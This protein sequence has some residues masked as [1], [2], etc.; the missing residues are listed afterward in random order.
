MSESVLTVAQMRAAEQAVMDQGTS[1]WELM[2]RAGTGAARWVSRMAG[3][4]PVTVLCGPGNNGGDGYVIAEILRSDGYDVT[5][6]APSDPKTGTA[7]TAKA[8]F[9][10]TVL[11][12]GSIATPVV[13]DCLFGYGL[14]REVSG[15]FA[16]LLEELK[17]HSCFKIAIDVPSCVASDDAK[18]LGPCFDYDLTLALGAWKPAHFLMPAAAIMG[19]KRLVPLALPMMEG[20]AELSHRPSFAIPAADTHK[21]KRGLV[22]VVEG[23]MPGAGLLA[24]IAAMRSGAGYVKL[25][26]DHSHPD[27]PADLVLESGDLDKLLSDERIGCVLVGPGLGRTQQSREKLQA[28]LSSGKRCVIDADALHLLDRASLSDVDPA[29]IILTPH[30]GELAALCKAFDVTS[31]DKLGRARALQDAAGVTVLA[32]G[33][34]TIL[35]GSG[36]TIFFPRGPSWL[37]VAGSGDVLAGILASRFAHH[38]DPLAASQEA[39]WLHN[40]AARRAG[41]AFCASDLAGAVGQASGAFL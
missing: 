11:A 25:L 2:R 38:H 9:G 37:S 7:S 41:P 19:I 20:A 1:E 3:G 13:V 33:P 12:R 18:V 15:D 27:A 6:I 36:R 24:S 21:Y 4:R 8:K 23:E 5:V 30:E 17:L 31:L 22:T 40:E 35:T 16:K 34:D 10:G 29:K 26:G 14:D 32:K 39:V 28:V